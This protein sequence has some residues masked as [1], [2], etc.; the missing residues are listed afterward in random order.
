MGSKMRRIPSAVPLALSVVVVAALT[1]CGGGDDK[2]DTSETTARDFLAAWQ[3][4]D[5]AKAAS[6]TDN[7]TTAQQG[8][9]TTGKQ[10]GVVKAE[11]KAGVYVKGKDGA[12]A[13]LAYNATLTL[14]G[15]ADPVK[16]ESIVPVVTA[17]GKT[18]V[19]W[20]QTIVHPQLADS[21]KIKR[22]RKLPTRGEILDRSGKA[23]ATSTPVVVLSLDPSKIKNPDALY[24][25]LSDP[26]FDLDIPKLKGRVAASDPKQAVS[27]VTLRKEKWDNGG[28]VKLAG[29]AEIQVRESTQQASD[30]AKQIVGTVG[31]GDNADLLKNADPSA[32]ATDAVGAS[33][34]QFRYEKK[35]AGTADLKIT[36]VD[37][38]GVAKATLVDVKGKPAEPLKTSLDPATQKRAE[39]ALKA[40]TGGKNASMV[41][42]DAKTGGILGAAN[43]PAN[44]DNRAFTGRYPPGSTFKT[45]SSGALLKAGLKPTDKVPCE[46]TLVVNGQT[47]KN[48]DGLKPMPDAL[49]QDDFA[50]S[51]NTAF[52]GNRGKIEND[53]LNKLA[54]Q[55]FGI[56]AK[57]DVGTV[58]FDGSVPAANG[59]ND[60]AA[61]MIGQGRVL[62]SP[63]VMASVAATIA[64]GK[65]NQPV[66]TPDDVPGRAKS[67]DLDP[68]IAGQLKALMQGV[69]ANG[70][71]KMLQ[72]IP[73]TVGAKTGTAEFDEKGETLTHGWMIAFKDDIAVAVLV[74]KGVSGGSAAGPVVN[75]FFR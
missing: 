42:I 59:E 68:A 65:F 20:T 38:G 13:T 25:A 70:S 10:L 60:K 41:V 75:A 73:G 33:G 14:K 40:V 55:Q 62:A 47:F 66:L 9:D 7:P 30:V 17:D 16:I 5:L 12:P 32:S 26:M 64:S 45:V 34:L 53:T 28:Q 35:L 61:S 15:V 51:C 18:R 43:T 58:T 8:L 69:V 46:N 27:L 74:E 57:W 29:L 6:F 31:S 3:G 11:Y 4:G 2:K 44:G 63:L 37:A 54:E 39:E 24:S 19:H 52:I 21:G 67:H 49:F 50:Q 72:G 1:S 22:E 23:L 36:V 56:G 48:Y 71:G